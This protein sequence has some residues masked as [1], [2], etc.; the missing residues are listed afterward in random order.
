M[1]GDAQQTPGDVY[2]TGETRPTGV[3]FRL[4]GDGAASWRIDGQL[5]SRRR[6]V[7]LKRRFRDP[8][9]V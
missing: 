9:G 8:G 5:D 3:Y 4:R 2:Y 1:A 6:L 7:V